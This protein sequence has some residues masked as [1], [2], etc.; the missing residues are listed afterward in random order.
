MSKQILRWY[1]KPR[2]LMRQVQCTLCGNE[3]WER[4]RVMDED[5]EWY[6][7]EDFTCACQPNKEDYDE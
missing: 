1:R 5:G 2:C 3:W 6:E 7:R 4:V